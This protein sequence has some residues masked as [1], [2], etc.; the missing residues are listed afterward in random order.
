MKISQAIIIFGLI[1]IF[2]GIVLFYSIPADPELE[3]SIRII[4]H[5]GTFIGLMGIGIIMA[6]ILLHLM[7]REDPQ[8]QEG[9]DV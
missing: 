9:L 3:D 4:K 7:G 8:I 6:G 2:S 5:G 1:M